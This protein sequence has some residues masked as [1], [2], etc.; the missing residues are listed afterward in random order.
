MRT[1]TPESAWVRI[2]INGADY[3]LYSAMVSMELN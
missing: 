2:L 3:R 1:A